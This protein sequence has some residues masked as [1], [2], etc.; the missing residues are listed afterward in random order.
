MNNN[1]K[2]NYQMHNL[3][4]TILL[5]A[6]MMLLLS[7]TGW[8][9]AGFIG[10][11]WALST[12]VILVIFAPRLSSRLILYFYEARPVTPQDSAQL[13]DLV[14]WLANRSKLPQR[15]KL[16]YIPSSV[17]MA[18]SVGI[19]N[20][21]SIAISDGLL[22]QLNIREIA[23][24]L[25]HEI[26]HIQHRDLW[27]MSVAD[28][29]SRITSLMALM[30][31]VMVLLYIPLFIFQGQPIPWLLLLIL[32][33]AP[34]IS[35]LMQLALSRTREFAAD[36]QAVKLTGDPPGLIS[37]LNKIHYYEKSWLT[38]LLL[39]NV[40][41]PNPSLL[42]THPLTEERIRRLRNLTQ[43][44]QHLYIQEQEIAH[45]NNN[46]AQGTPRHHISGLW[47]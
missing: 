46:Q 28:I 4:N 44:D 14:K 43:N 45:F 30:G 5:L 34:S 24:V 16:Y 22:R 27:L 42:R 10:I 38:H 12:G 40:R 41:V 3:L 1:I 20:D 15:P 35:A 13:T 39:P 18:F 32:M 2:Q 8:L 17:M 21:T 31:Y 26:S 29:L 9:V 23:A 33:I 47:Y 37:A 6:G 7:L 25:A 11:I 19:R 36:M